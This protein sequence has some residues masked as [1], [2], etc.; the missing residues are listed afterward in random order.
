M[1]ASRASFG[2]AAVRRRT[3]ARAGEVWTKLH[4]EWGVTCLARGRLV[5]LSHRTRSLQP[6]SPVC[7]LREPERQRGRAL[8]RPTAGRDRA[9]RRAGRARQPRQGGGGLAPS[10]ENYLGR[11]TKAQILAAVREA[12]RP[13]ASRSRRRSTW[14]SEAECLLD[15]IGW[16]PQPLRTPGLESPPLPFAET[17]PAE[18]T[19]DAGLPEMNTREIRHVLLGRC[20][21]GDGD[22]TA[23]R[24]DL[25]ACGPVL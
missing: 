25:L 15:G 8:V 21:V 24:L 16:L 23:E 19:S 6:R 14:A 3:V 10:V 18:M 22:G 9:C 13:S 5:G 4:D 7:V 11:V 20:R 12:K 2:R 17:E 1:S